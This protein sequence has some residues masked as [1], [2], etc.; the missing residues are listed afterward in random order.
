MHYELYIDI[1]FTVNMLMDFL[2][3]FVVKMWLKLSASIFRL[4][5]ASLYGA[6]VICMY[7][8]SPWRGQFYLMI[9]SWIAACL[10]MIQIAFKSASP[11]SRGKAML[12]YYV[13]SI[14]FNGLF[15][16]YL[17]NVSSFLQ[18][19]AV[20]IFLLFA[21]KGIFY[22]FRRFGRNDKLIYPVELRFH[23][24]SIRLKGL[25]DTGNCLI[26]PF[27]QRGVSII[28][29][30]A[31]KPYFSE[32]LQYRIQWYLGE[33][34]E[35]KEQTEK[36]EG[37]Q[38]EEELEEQS[39][40]DQ[41]KIFVIPFQT[42]GSR[43]GMMPVLTVDSIRIDKQGEWIEYRRALLGITKSDIT[44]QKKYQMILSPKG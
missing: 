43:H 6:A 13:V 25:W 5:V 40:V 24:E 31:I 44:S 14:F 35:K 3:L 7:I 20:I 29:Y 9:L 27:H 37:K 36:K 28:S 23:G 12:A 38:P 4:V 39:V 22:A 11:K 33:E 17:K 8:L 32:E 18:L 21:V 34:N 26:S 15:Q 30:A 41:E 10:G 19:G 1:F 16:R 2:V 42:I